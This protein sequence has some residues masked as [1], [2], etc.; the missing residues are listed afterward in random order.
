[1][2]GNFRE[3]KL[4]CSKESAYTKH[5]LTPDENEIKTTMLQVSR[6]DDYG[7]HMDIADGRPRRTHVGGPA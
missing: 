5:G 6:L 2:Q 1:M 3:N 4:Y 7:D